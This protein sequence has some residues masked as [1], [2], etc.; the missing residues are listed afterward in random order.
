MCQGKRSEGEVRNGVR[1]DSGATGPGPGRAGAVFVRM[2]FE[3]CA[4]FTAASPVPGV[5]RSGVE[6]ARRAERSEAVFFV[7]VF[8]IRRGSR[9]RPARC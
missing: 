6:V 1:R 8:R 5:R 4:F 2:R 3:R 7:L 9:R